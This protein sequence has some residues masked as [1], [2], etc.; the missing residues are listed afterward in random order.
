MMVLAGLWPRALA[1][2][3]RPVVVADWQRVLFPAQR[4]FSR[5]TARQP[6]TPCS[7]TPPP[8][9]PPPPFPPYADQSSKFLT[10]YVSERFEPGRVGTVPVVGRTLTVSSFSPPR[11]PLQVGRT[12]PGCLLEWTIP[13]RPT[14]SNE[15]TSV[16]L[17]GKDLQVGSLPR[18]DALPQ[19]R[20]NFG[21]LET[22]LSIAE[23]RAQYVAEQEAMRVKHGSGGACGASG[24]PLSPGSSGPT[25]EG[26]FVHKGGA[27][28]ALP[29]SPLSS[30][31]PGEVPWRGPDGYGSS[32]AALYESY[33][34]SRWTAETPGRAYAITSRRSHSL[35]HVTIEGE[36]ACGWCHGESGCQCIDHVTV[37]GP[38]RALALH[39]RSRGRVQVSVTAV[40]SLHVRCTSRC[41][42]TLEPTSSSSG[43]T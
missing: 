20:R 10:V 11:H 23:S 16:C 3:P 32:D 29:V 28:G 17:L 18:V 37:R 33:Y 6:N 5:A 22:R 4:V 26:P 40:R 25:S 27:S 24:L 19:F 9:L 38:G 14:S 31:S 1:W 34:G 41:R 7:H 12:E 43:P 35:G 2:C 30:G 13:R 21:G 42:H 36:G 8:P 15:P 39:G